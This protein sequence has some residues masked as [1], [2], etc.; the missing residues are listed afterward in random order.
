MELHHI[1]LDR[2]Q[3]LIQKSKGRKDRYV[4][5]AKS[6]KPLLMNYLTTYQPKRFF[7]EG[8][9]SEKYTAGSI[10]AFL[11]TSCKSAAIHKHITPH[12]LRHSFATHMIESGV[13]LRYVQQ[14][15]GHKNSKTT[16]IYTH[17][18][19]IALQQITNPLDQLDFD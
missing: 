18:T 1:D 8:K 17:I 10:R 5:L 6:F 9:P 13:N 7:I 2:N 12:S 3:I 11:K 4:P 15:L 19:D 16:E 14:I